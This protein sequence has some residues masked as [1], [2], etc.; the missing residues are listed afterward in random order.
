[1]MVMVII[2]VLIIG[3]VSWRIHAISNASLKR[4]FWSLLIFK[5]TAGLLLGYIYTHH[6]TESD[7][8]YFFREAC[9]LADSAKE[10]LSGYAVSLWRDSTGAFTGESRTLFIVKAASLFALIASNNYW[11]TSLYFSWIAFTGAWWLLHQINRVFPQMTFP[12]MIGLFVFPSSVFWTSGVTK[13]SLA[14][15]AIFVLAGI[16]IRIWNREPLTKLTISM[17]LIAIW[18]AWTLKYFYVGVFFAV[19]TSAWL[20]RWFAENK[21]RAKARTPYREFVLFIV[22]LL[23]MLFVVTFI[24]PNFYPRQ[25]IEVVVENNRLFNEASGNEGIIHFQQLEPTLGSILRNAPWALFSVLLRPFLW[26][27]VNLLQFLAAAENM[28][29]ILLMIFAVRNINAATQTPHRLLLIAVMVY[30]IML[31]VLLALSAPNFG[32]LVRYRVGFLP[33]L[34]ILLSYRLL[35]PSWEARLLKSV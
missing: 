22:M 24:H 6:Y 29:L 32:T 4:W 21:M 10:D 12:G 8:V 33:F 16:F 31:G 26:E 34:V 19:T 13:E 3:V 14:M 20:T 1:M 18:V 27:A 35:P 5:L 9:A 11:L 17:A 28:I 23:V 15:A 30:I 25:L 7:T 2:H